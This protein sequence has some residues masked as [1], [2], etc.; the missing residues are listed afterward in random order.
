M[1]KTAVAILLIVVIVGA[2]LIIACSKSP[3]TDS[4]QNTKSAQEVSNTV[5]PATK[6]TTTA[7]DASKK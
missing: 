7:T 5:P 3:S 6:G 1:N 2:F 4:S